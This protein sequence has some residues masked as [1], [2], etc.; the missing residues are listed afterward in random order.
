MISTSANRDRKLNEEESSSPDKLWRITKADVSQL[1]LHP[2]PDLMVHQSKSYGIR[3]EPSMERKPMRLLRFQQSLFL[4][5]KYYG[6]LVLHASKE[7][8]PADI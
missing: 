5:M 7:S 1:F 4:G 3:K 2:L 8:R 6:G